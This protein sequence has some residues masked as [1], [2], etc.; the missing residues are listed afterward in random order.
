MVFLLLSGIHM[1]WAAGGRWGSQAVFP[2]KTSE[3]KAIMPGAGP[4]LVVAIGLLAMGLFVMLKTGLVTRS[5]PVW[6]DQ[7]GLWI[8]AGI[9]L[10]RSI[11]DF[12]YVG[13]FK[14]IKHTPFGHNDTRYYSP[15]C[16]AVGL[17][18]VALELTGS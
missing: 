7:Y 1:Y 17:L 13:F 6:F 4:T 9:F 10:L 2:T 12:T 16:L 14:T 15:L 18:T 5:I 11:G 8:I 3:T